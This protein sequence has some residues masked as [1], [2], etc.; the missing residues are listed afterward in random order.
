[1]STDKVFTVSVTNVNEAPTLTLP[2]AQ[3]ACEDVDLAITGLSV[4]D[5][6][7]G[8]LTVTLSVGHGRLTLGTTAG[9]TVSG[10]GTG[11]VTLSGGAAA[12]N[13][14]LAGLAYRGGLNYSGTDT[15]SIGV[16]DGGLSTSASVAISVKSALQ[17]AADLQAQ[18]RALQAAG[19]LNGP[20]ANGLL[21]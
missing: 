2:A 9:L 15:L 1:L 14:A 17:Q 6:E 5:P 8:R 21:S 16:S 10:N 13:A 19:A 7:G 20:Q 11:A 4:G 12:L 3:A 18:V